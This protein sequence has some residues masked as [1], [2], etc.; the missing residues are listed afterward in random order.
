MP[1]ARKILDPAHPVVRCLRCDTDFVRQRKDRRFCSDACANAGRKD[2]AKKARTCLQCGNEYRTNVGTQK[3]CSLLCANR[4][5]DAN[6][7]VPMTCGH[8]CKEFLARRKTRRFC[9][10]ACANRS[11]W[12]S[13][14]SRDCQHCGKPFPAKSAADANRRYCSRACAK[15]STQKKISTWHA[16]HPEAST[17][18]RRTRLAKNPGYY[19]EKARRERLE[20][21]RLLGGGCCVCGVTNPNWLHVDYIPTNKASPYRHPRHLAFVRRHLSDFRLLC[22]NHH[23]ELTLTGRI[24]GTEI[25]Q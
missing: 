3:C 16:E 2:R 23:Y 1:A 15:A 4:Y 14:K 12:A 7:C 20:S 10:S 25:T 6:A 18:Y 24:E 5:R 21:I 8:C 13:G 22:A 19:R 17:Q 9:S 11:E